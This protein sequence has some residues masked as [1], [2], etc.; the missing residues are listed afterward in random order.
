MAAARKSRSPEM[1]REKE[2]GNS[3]RSSDKQ[4][5]T[6]KSNGHSGITPEPPGLLGYQEGNF[7]F[8][9][10]LAMLLPTVL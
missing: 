2:G 5:L 9:Q 7:L 4:R 6:Y 3:G 1:K 10:A 8:S